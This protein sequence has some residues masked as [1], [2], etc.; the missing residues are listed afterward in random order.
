[1]DVADR[2]LEITTA[3]SRT[4]YAVVVAAFHCW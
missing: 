1:V 4:C 2:L 3:L